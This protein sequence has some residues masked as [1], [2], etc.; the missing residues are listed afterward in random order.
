ML[1][2]YDLLPDLVAVRVAVRVAVWKVRRK[3]PKANDIKMRAFAAAVLSNRKLID[4]SQLEL[5]MTCGDRPRPG[6]GYDF[7][8]TKGPTPI[9][10]WHN[11]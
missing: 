11:G 7:Q 6:G 5:Y 8:H 10:P 1:L 4:V 2:Q 9:H 3:D